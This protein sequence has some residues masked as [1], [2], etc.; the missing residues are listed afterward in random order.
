MNTRLTFI[1]IFILYY[2]I[3]NYHHI[4]WN[5]M[6]NLTTQILLIRISIYMYQH[7]KEKQLCVN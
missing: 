5:I 3:L 1:S 4:F 7:I 6:Y 2:K